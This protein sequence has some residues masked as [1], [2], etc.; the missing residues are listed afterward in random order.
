MGMAGRQ[1]AQNR[2]EDPDDINDWMSWRNAQARAPNSTPTPAGPQ[3]G[4]LGDI[5]F[6]EIVGAG[7]GIAQGPLGFAQQAAFSAALANPFDRALNPPG[8]SAFDQVSGAANQAGG[9]I[10][11][12]VSDPRGALQDARDALHR[13]HIAFDPTASSP[14]ATPEDERARNFKIGEN[15][16]QLGFALGSLIAGSGLLAGAAGFGKMRGTLGTA[17]YADEGFSPAQIEHL[18]SQYTGMGH[19]FWPR[20]GIDIGFGLKLKL[21]PSLSES[22]LNVLKPE[23]MTR[24]EFY[25]LHHGVDPQFYGARMPKSDTGLH[26]S[27]KKLGLQKYSLPERLWYGSPAP[28]K[29]AL[30]A[31][32]AAAG[33]GNMTTSKREE[34]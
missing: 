25:E 17:R 14:A 24:G 31:P 22:S 7:K 19:H 16:G 3:D 2:A 8:Q 10:S 4:G 5:I 33:F 12:V 15:Q 34:P 32:A 1:L 30:G 29:A 18:D 26:W 20:A 11:H 9:Y 28:L 23:G 21:P 27:G 13:L 6:G